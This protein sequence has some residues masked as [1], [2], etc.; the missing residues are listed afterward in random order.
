LAWPDTLARRGGV[1]TS[2]GRIGPKYLAEKGVAAVGP[3]PGRSILFTLGAARVNGAVQAIIN[4]IA[5]K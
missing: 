4:P 2:D 1:P 3:I 5:I